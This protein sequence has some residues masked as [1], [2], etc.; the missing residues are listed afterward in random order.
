[1]KE[2]SIHEKLAPI[3][4][5]GSAGG[6]VWLVALPNKPPLSDLISRLGLIAALFELP[7]DG[8]ALLGR[9]LR[10]YI[11]KRE[12]S[13]PKGSRFQGYPFRLRQC[14]SF[15]LGKGRSFFTP[16]L[17]YSS[18][19]FSSDSH[20]GSRSQ[21]SL[22]SRLDASASDHFFP[23]YELPACR[24]SLAFSRKDRFRYC[25]SG[26]V[27]VPV[28]ILSQWTARFSF[29]N[30]Y[31]LREHEYGNPIR[32]IYPALFVFQSASPARALSARQR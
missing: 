32:K 31:H 27:L 3:G 24:I 16:V 17:C 1:M 18:R 26:R 28:P 19:L 6:F 12:T 30:P 14:F 9:V 23:K 11:E 15:F 25:T 2:P 10:V 21:K 5:V 8:D 20:V 29:S 13:H 4:F 22:R 7:L